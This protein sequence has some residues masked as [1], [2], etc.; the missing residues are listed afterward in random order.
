MSQAHRN[1][2]GAG[3]TQNQGNVLGDRPAV[4]QSRLFREHDS[5]NAMKD[6][7]GSGETKWKTDQQEG[8]Y[9][10]RALYDHNAPGNRTKPQGQSQQYHQQ[11]EPQHQQQQQQHQQQYQQQNLQQDQQ[12][13]Q[14][15]GWQLDQLQQQQAQPQQQQQQQQPQHQQQQYQQQQQQQNLQQQRVG[16][17]ADIPKQNYHT[18]GA[19]FNFFSGE[20]K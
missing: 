12:Q 5:G 15:Q 3:M 11:Q 8:A 10:G 17:K 14:Q 6:L 19:G 7:M 16:T 9:A 20:S 18:H 4:R 2:G 13:D 1:L